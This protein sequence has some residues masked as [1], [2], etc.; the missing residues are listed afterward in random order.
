MSTVLQAEHCWKYG[1]S[2][3]EIY[4]AKFRGED[5]EVF[6]V[7]LYHQ[8]LV[9]L[10]VADE[11]WPREE[12]LWRPEIQ[13]WFS[14][15]FEAAIDTETSESWRWYF[16]LVVAKDR[17]RAKDL[18]ALEMS[19]GLGISPEAKLFED[20]RGAMIIDHHPFGLKIY[21]KE[22]LEISH[23]NRGVIETEEAAK[24]VFGMEHFYAFINPDESLLEA[25]E[26]ID[27]EEEE[28]EEELFD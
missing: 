28:S 12:M 4:Q 21:T 27:E 5:L 13:K 3:W 19:K 14:E 9:D 7:R 24:A 8:D 16:G 2:L 11:M 6:S 1:R 26:E 10:K 22:Q 15:E 23:S 18:L 25:V 20:I 17:N